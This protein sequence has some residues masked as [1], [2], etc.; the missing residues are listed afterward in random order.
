MLCTFYYSSPLLNGILYDTDMHKIIK[1]S[2]KIYWFY[3]FL[4]G[5]MIYAANKFDKIDHLFISK[6]IYNSVTFVKGYIHAT[7]TLQ[8]IKKN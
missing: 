3:T 5:A 2:P 1:I 7:D 8:N 6:N 4:Y